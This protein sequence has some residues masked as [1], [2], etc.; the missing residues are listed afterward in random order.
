MKTG[1]QILLICGLIFASCKPSA[2]YERNTDGSLS[3]IDIEKASML[4]NRDQKYYFVDVYT[5]WCGWC[6]VMDKKTFTDQSVIDYLDKNFHVVKFDAE[7]TGMV[8]WEGKEYVYKPGGRKGIHELAPQLLNNRLS[9]PSFAV[10][11]KNRKIIG[12]LVGYKKPDQL[13]SELSV[14]TGTAKS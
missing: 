11:D 5:E 2:E 12:T 9:Y 10:L 13:L 4:Q 3:W 6:K 8:T 14:M 7:Q 1:I